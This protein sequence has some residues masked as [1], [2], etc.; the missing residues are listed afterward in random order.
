MLSVEHARQ[1]SG[2]GR[3]LVAAAEAFCAANGRTTMTLVL[4]NLRVELPPLYRKLGY[5]ETGTEPWPDSQ[6]DRASQPCHF[7]V[8]SKAIAGNQ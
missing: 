1:K 4:V 3:E 7:I 2:I 8:M 5:A 6:R